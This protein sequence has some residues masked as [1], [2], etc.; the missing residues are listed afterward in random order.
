[1]CVCI[2][3]YVYVSHTCSMANLVLQFKQYLL[4]V[5]VTKTVVLVEGGV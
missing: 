1:M 5:G 4:C 2:Y 3:I